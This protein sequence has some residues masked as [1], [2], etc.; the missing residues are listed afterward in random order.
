MERTQKKRNRF[1]RML[2]TGYFLL[3]FSCTILS[4]I[5]DSVTV[6]KAVTARAKEKSVETRITGTGTV[7][8]QE[9][10][11]S[12]VIPGLRIQSVAAEPGRQ[13]K[14][15]EELF[16]YEED[17][18]AEQR[19]RLWQEKAKL[20]LELEKEEI[21]KEEALSV[22]ESELAAW[23][24]AM[25]ER[26]LSEGR[27]EQEMNHQEAE[28]ERERLREDYERKQAMTREELWAQ[29]NQEE[30]STRQEL[31]SAKNS[32]NSALRKARR[33]VEDR[34]R[35][36][37]E[38]E[39]KEAT[40]SER[41]QKEQELKRAREDLEDLEEE[42]EDQLEDVE[43]RMDWIDDRNERIR[44][45]SDSSQMA[46][47]ET[48]EEAL[49]QLE[50]RQKEEDKAL[51]E[52][53]KRV[54]QARWNLEIASRKDEQAR[55]NRDQKERLSG[56]IQKGIQM[57]IQKKEQELKRLEALIAAGGRV[58]AEQ[59][60]TVV[61]C[62]LLTARTTTGEERLILASDSF[63]FEGEF[64]KE[65]QRLAVGDLL[66]LSVPGSRRKQE[67]RIREMN[68]LGETMGSFRAELAGT[69]LFLGTV[70]GYECIKQSETY[71][72]VIPLQG[73]RKDTKGY[74]CLIARPRRAILGEE[75]VAERVEVRVLEL[76]DT[77]AAVEG[78]LQNSDEIIV[79][80]NQIIGE[81]TRVRPV[82]EF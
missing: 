74:Y 42:W 36:L 35:E 41:A 4:R 6:P 51:K 26:E 67:V 13:V 70:T 49:R 11:F 56:L 19:E 48:Y 59:D 20:G 69:E 66:Q 31:R 78:A 50:E 58:L 81:G 14:K 72:K 47:L 24:L 75:F 77:E 80:S 8:E 46:L 18:M 3:M 33:T 27:Q 71:Q 43:L 38:L 53:E 39:N 7:R 5:Y 28:K 9:T 65:E 23:E 64:V 63:C 30:E 60:G 79:R 45:G 34:E 10:F 44:S 57:D 25:A 62:E 15:G 22:T 73:L 76:G 29:Q 61:A 37:E 82:Q 16:C 40:E 55:L 12:P 21:A 54:E 32:R 68:L 52:R 17:S 1:Y 2:L